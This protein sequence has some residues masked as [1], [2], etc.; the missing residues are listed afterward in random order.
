MAQVT[1][2]L[3]H[4]LQMSNFNMFDFTYPITDSSW[5]AELERDIKNHYYFHEIGVETPDRFKQRLMSKMNEIMP[6]YDKLHQTMLLDFNPLITHRKTETFEG[7]SESSGNVSSTDNTK[8][9]EYPQTGNPASDIA[10]GMDNTSG[11]SQSIS[12]GAND[13]ERTEEGF[14]GDQ[15]ELIRSY[16]QNILNLNLRIIEELRP[17]FILI[18]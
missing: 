6:Y 1:I 11:S 8:T 4:L 9:Y 2:E 17:L 5:K 15:S 10:A 3:R 16:R 12:S 14:D 13:Y 18:Y 7:S